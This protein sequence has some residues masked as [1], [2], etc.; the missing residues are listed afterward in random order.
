MPKLK[1]ALRLSRPSDAFVPFVLAICAL[2]WNPNISLGLFVGCFAVSALSLF[3]CFGVR[4]AFAMQP[5]MRSVR[6]T[7]K[8][9][10][11]LQLAGGLIAALLGTLFLKGERDALPLV[12][13]GLLLNIEHT[14]YE[15]L[16]AA[17][18][19]R[20]AMLSHGLTAAFLIA[21]MSLAK[22]PEG[23]HDL[24]KLVAMIGISAA[25]SAVI[26]CAMGDGL[27]GRLNAQILR[28]APRAAL[29]VALYPAIALL[30]LWAMNPTSCAFPFFAGWTLCA[31]CRT[32]F[33]RSSMEALPLNRSLLIT[34]AATAAVWVVLTFIPGLTAGID[35]SSLPGSLLAQ[36][37]TACV[38]V[39]AAA[40]CSFALYGNLKKNKDEYHE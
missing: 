37:P 38:L 8:C 26:G 18:D 2:L 19:W 29:Q 9:A 13:A 11:L 17:G 33:R 22:G 30:I 23:S 39:A 14:F 5:S 10:L 7:V 40:A 20:S 32:P 1:R 4:A 16:Y 3:S 27:K 6:G 28:C 21:G 31:L 24:W 15:Y 12:A 34:F 35:A 25:V 36:L